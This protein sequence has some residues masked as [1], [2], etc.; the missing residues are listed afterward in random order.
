[1]MRS[2]C[3]AGYAGCIGAFLWDTGCTVGLPDGVVG[4]AEILAGL[5]QGDG[6]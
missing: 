2:C 5:E 6:D 4:R 1:M 3:P